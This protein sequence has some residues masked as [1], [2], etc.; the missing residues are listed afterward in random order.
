M[1]Y[2]MHDNV[3]NKRFMASADTAW[4]YADTQVDQM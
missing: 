3:N 1:Y 2:S 4:S